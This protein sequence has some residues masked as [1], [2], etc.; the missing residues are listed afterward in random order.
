LRYDVP[1]DGLRL[2]SRSC[3]RMYFLKRL[4]LLISLAL[5]TAHGVSAHEH[6]TDLQ[7]MSMPISSAESALVTTA[8]ASSH[9]LGSVAS[10]SGHPCG[11]DHA[12]CCCVTTCGVHCG[13]LLAVFQFESHAL[14]SAHPQPLPEL[15]QDGLTHAPPVRPPIG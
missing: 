6:V 10:A 2:D 3:N 7:N 5:F 4:L 1:V 8:D 14:D 15:R 9:C 13:A 11:R 12:P